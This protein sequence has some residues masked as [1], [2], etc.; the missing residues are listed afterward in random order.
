MASQLETLRDRSSEN[1]QSKSKNKT[2]KI[3]R[4][5]FIQDSNS[6]LDRNKLNIASKS[7]RY[8]DEY[9]VMS[10]RTVDTMKESGK[11]PLPF[12]L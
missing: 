9:L 11:R 3:F 7:D 10:D 8:T 2:H 12:I 6:N 1:R 4:L 5:K